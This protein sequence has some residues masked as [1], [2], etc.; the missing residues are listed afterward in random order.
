M[1]KRKDALKIKELNGG[2]SK[3]TEKV[4]KINQEVQEQQ[5]KEELK[6][7]QEQTAE[8]VNNFL[9]TGPSEEEDQRRLLELQKA[10]HQIDEEEARL[11]KERSRVHAEADAIKKREIDEIARRAKAKA[12]ADDR[13]EAVAKAKAKSK[14]EADA[15]EAEKAN[16][17]NKADGTKPMTAAELEAEAQMWQKAIEDGE[18]AFEA[19]K[20]KGIAEVERL[21]AEAKRV[22]AEEEKVRLAAI[23]AAKAEEAKKAAEAKKAEEAAKAEKEAAEAVCNPGPKKIYQYKSPKTKEIHTTSDIWAAEQAAPG[24][25]KAVWVWVGSNG[26]VHHVLTPEEIAEYVQ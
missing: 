6:E 23:E 17:A 5:V 21:K 10:I 22:A 18:K 13:A 14:A 12:Q 7:A 19:K 20:A 11:K 1:A 8:D 9:L 25:W 3:K 16:K 24:R 26:K 2:K 15:K 4:E